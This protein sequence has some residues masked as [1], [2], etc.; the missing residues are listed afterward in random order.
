MLLERLKEDIVEGH[1]LEI[2]DLSSIFYI[3][4]D[5]SN[6]GMVEVLLKA[7]EFSEAINAGSQEKEGVGVNLTIP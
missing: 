5:W 4:A 2:L 3:K 1:T 7:D 6:Y